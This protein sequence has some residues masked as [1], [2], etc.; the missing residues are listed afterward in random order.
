[1]PQQNHE[2]RR[3]IPGKLSAMFL[4][5]IAGQLDHGLSRW[6]RSCRAALPGRF[7]AALSNYFRVADHTLST[8]QE[9]V[10]HALIFID[11][12]TYGNR[13]VHRICE[14]SKLRCV[15]ASVP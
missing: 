2:A 12:A 1:M 13:D 7:P 8:S 10:Y 6:V 4:S 5:S 9:G 14:P 15:A 11:A 3:S